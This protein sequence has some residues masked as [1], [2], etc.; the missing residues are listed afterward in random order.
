MFVTFEGPEGS[1]K[2]VQSEKL[3]NRLSSDG[4]DVL[5]TREPG[6]TA[7]GD[8][9]RDL[10][11][12]KDG[13]RLSGRVEALLFNASRAALVEEVLRP[14]LVEGKIVVCD[15]YADSTIAYQCYGRGLSIDE[16]TGLNCFA[17]DDLTPDI[18]FLLDINPAVGL[19]RKINSST[20]WARFETETLAFHQRVAGGYRAMAEADPMRWRV[21]DASGRI[22]SI[23]QQIWILIVEELEC[24]GIKARKGGAIG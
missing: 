3:V 23:E 24:R 18:T 14:A 17:T 12:A 2:S 8:I 1:G 15:R 22:Q 10:V 11:R 21:V 19:K 20:E 13:P 4:F 5:L 7:L 16:V 9:I 6:G